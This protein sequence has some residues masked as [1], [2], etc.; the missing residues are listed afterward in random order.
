MNFYQDH[1]MKSLFY[2]LLRTLIEEK[3]RN[4]LSVVESLNVI[5]R[6]ELILQLKYWGKED[7]ERTMD[8][9]LFSELEDKK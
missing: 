5:H 2:A 8:N 3:H 1:A 4:R 9:E 6:I 7:I